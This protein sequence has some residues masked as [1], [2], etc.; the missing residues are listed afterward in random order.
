M[1]LA[2]IRHCLCSEKTGKKRCG[3]ARVD[4]Q[5]WKDYIFEEDA[6]YIDGF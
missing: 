3:T 4:V 6:V 5:R 2:V 1:P